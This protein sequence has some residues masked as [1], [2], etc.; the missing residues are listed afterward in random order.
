MSSIVFQ[1]LNRVKEELNNHPQLQISVDN[2]VEEIRIETNKPKVQHTGIPPVNKLVSRSEPKVMTISEFLNTT[3]FD[4][5]KIPASTKKSTISKIRKGNMKLSRSKIDNEYYASN[6]D[7]VTLL[8][9]LPDVHTQNVA[10]YDY[11]Y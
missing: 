1:L 5:V 4:V 6:N 9:E 3:K 7:I 11:F 10:V 8:S 2:L